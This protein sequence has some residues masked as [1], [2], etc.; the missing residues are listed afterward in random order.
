M[1]VDSVP[2]KKGLLIGN[3]QQFWLRALPLLV[4][5]CLRIHRFKRDARQFIPP[6]FGVEGTAIPALILLAVDLL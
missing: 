2:K 1:L 6:I 5:D 3:K 4:I